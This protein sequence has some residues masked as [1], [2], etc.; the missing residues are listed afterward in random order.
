MNSGQATCDPVGVGAAWPIRIGSRDVRGAPARLPRAKR[1]ASLGR[2]G[3]PGLHWPAAPRFPPPPVEPAM[4]GRPLPMCRPGRGSRRTVFVTGARNASGVVGRATSA[5]GRRDNAV[6]APGRAKTT[7][8]GPWGG[9]VHHCDHGSESLAPS[10]HSRTTRPG[11]SRLFPGAVGSSYAGAAVHAPGKPLRA[12]DSPWR[13]GPGHLNRQVCETGTNRAR[14]TRSTT[15]SH[16][17]LPNTATTTTTP[18][19]RPLRHNQ[20]SIK[21]RMIRSPPPRCGGRFIRTIRLHPSAR[22]AL[23]SEYE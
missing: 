11:G 7:G 20:P 15:T 19:P 21:L 8:R 13:D 12:R 23:G 16:P 10:P 22:Q 17:R 2:R 18:P 9:L 4:G 3:E 6:G 1:S 5:R 14:P